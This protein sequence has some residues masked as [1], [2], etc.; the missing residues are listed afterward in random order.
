MVP[1]QLRVGGAFLGIA[2]ALV[3]Y[4]VVGFTRGDEGFVITPQ[5]LTVLVAVAL[6]GA[7]ATTNKEQQGSRTQVIALFIAIVL[8]G[9]G[10]ILPN[11]ALFTTTPVWLL[12][13]D[14]TAQRATE[15]L[16]RFPLKPTAHGLLN[17]V[18]TVGLNLCSNAP[19][20]IP[21]PT[22]A[23]V[24]EWRVALQQIGT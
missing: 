10:V 18:Q 11:T 20:D 19:V 21:D 4:A 8:I 14:S 6:V 22:R 7:F 5:V 15:G 17:R 16:E 23:A 24:D 13:R 12:R 9:L 1:V 2:A 3:L